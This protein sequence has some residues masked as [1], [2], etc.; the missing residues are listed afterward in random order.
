MDLQK[1]ILPLKVSFLLS[2]AQQ[3]NSDLGR[4]TVEASSSYIIR[5]T[6]TRWDSSV[7]VIS[8]SQRPLPTQYTKETDIHA[9]SAIR[10]RDPRNQANAEFRACTGIGSQ[11][12]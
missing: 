12:Y 9:V 10:T 5:H 1:F 11:T 3:L 2:V 8:S 7:S 4:L 6:Q